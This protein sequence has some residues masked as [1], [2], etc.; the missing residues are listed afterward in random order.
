MRHLGLLLTMDLDQASRPLSVLG[1]RLYRLWIIQ[2]PDKR[3]D[4]KDGKMD[5]EWVAFTAIIQIS[6]PIKTEIADEDEGN[7]GTAD[8]RDERWN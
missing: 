4:A 5:I 3:N 2:K 7:I 6:D 1:K 8:G